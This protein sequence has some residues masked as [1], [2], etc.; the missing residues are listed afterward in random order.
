MSNENIYTHIKDVFIDEDES[1]NFVNLDNSISCYNKIVLALKKPLKLIL[2]Y[3]KPGSGKTF[4]LNKIANDLKEDKSL[5]FFPHPFFS[6]ATFIEALCEQI[7]GKKLEDINNFESFIKFYSKDFSSKDEI[8]KNQM[9]VILDEAQLYP[10]ELIEKIRLMADTRMFK[11]LFT[12]HKT[13]NED[14]L[15]K[16]YFQTRIWESI[17]LSSADVNEIIIY[18]QRKL[19]Q[20]NYDKYLKFDKKD[21]ECA[22]S[23]CGGNLRTLNKIMYKF[24]EICEYYEQYQPSKL[25]GDKANIM[26][27]TM[28]AL[29]AGLID[30]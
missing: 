25:S 22:Y 24:Y 20:K 16:D 27:L 10:T 11:F 15:A 8:L 1:L 12:I 30:A 2:F 5:I 6:E 18:L 17:E 23:F 9:T 21:Y 7:Y 26:I 4:L 28:A 3:G 14:I 29:D 13:E 19:S